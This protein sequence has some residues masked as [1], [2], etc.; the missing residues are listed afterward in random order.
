MSFVCCL[1]VRNACIVA[2]WTL[3]KDTWCVLPTSI[4]Y[5]SKQKNVRN[6]VTI[7]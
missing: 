2:E 6:F 1:F 5:V 7:G 4:I 3:F